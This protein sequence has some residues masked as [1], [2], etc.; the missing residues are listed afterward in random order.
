VWLVF[1]VFKRVLGLALIVA[2]AFGAWV[3]WSNPELQRSLIAFAVQ[4]LG[5]R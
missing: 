3:V 4:F 2:L 1:S 5:A